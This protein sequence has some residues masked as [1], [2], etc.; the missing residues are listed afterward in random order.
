MPSIR[1]LAERHLPGDGY[2]IERREFLDGDERTLA[3]HHVGW[4]PTNHVTY[5]LWKDLGQ[6]WV[7][8][9]EHDVRRDRRVYGYELSERAI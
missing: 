6:I 9:Y 8:Y 3:V 2:T 7:E 1:D 4:S 5:R